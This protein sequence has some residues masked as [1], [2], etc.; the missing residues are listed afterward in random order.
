MCWEYMR[1]LRSSLD[2]IRYLSTRSDALVDATIKTTSLNSMTTEIERSDNKNDMLL[3]QKH[4][5]IHTVIFYY[6]R[7]LVNCVLDSGILTKTKC[8]A[9]Y[10]CCQTP[11]PGTFPLFQMFTF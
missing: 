3:Q 10:I 1:S 4:M 6:R 7:C 11:S 2:S 5:Y 8:H 9:C